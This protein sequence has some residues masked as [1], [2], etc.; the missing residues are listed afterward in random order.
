MRL[1]GYRFV[2]GQATAVRDRDITRF[3]QLERVARDAEGRPRRDSTTKAPVIETVPVPGYEVKPEGWSPTV[4]PTTQLEEPSQTT[5][6]AYSR[7]LPAKKRGKPRPFKARREIEVK[8]APAVE[9]PAEEADN[10]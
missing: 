7:L 5:A 10:G 1:F 4:E 9:E 6:D 3:E 8:D 2:R